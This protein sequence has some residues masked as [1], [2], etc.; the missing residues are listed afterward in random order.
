MAIEISKQ[1]PLITDSK[2][3]KYPFKSMGVGDWFEVQGKGSRPMCISVTKFMKKYPGYKFVVR[4]F[5][6]HVKVWRIK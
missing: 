4:Q 3:N 1:V 2:K 6:G 5:P